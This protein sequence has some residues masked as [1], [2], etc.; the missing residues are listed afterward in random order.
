MEEPLVS[1]GD[2]A[3]SGENLE[4]E[5]VFTDLLLAAQPGEEKQAGD[6]IIAAEEPKDSDV[7]E[8]AR[9][10]LALSHDLRAA[11]LL[12]NSELRMNGFAGFAQVTSYIRGCLQEYWE[13]CHPQLD[14]E[15]DDDPTMRVNAALGLAG[16][17]T[18]IRA[19]RVAPLTQSNSFGRIGLRDIAVADGEVPASPDAEQVLDQAGIAAAFKDTDS[20]VLKEIYSA[21]S[22]ALEDV[23]AINTVFDEKIPGLG[24]D[25]DPLIKVLNRAVSRLAEET[26]EENIADEEA[27]GEE[28]AAPQK[29]GAGTGAITSPRDVEMALDRI[30]VYYA[31]FEPSSPLPILLKR[32]KRLVGADFMTIVKDIAPSGVDNV[33][34]VGGIE[35]EG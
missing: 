4:Y 9:E 29:A 18:V 17:D 16:S 24:P 21:A 2:D 12:A 13:T 6:E 31:S 5:K 26:G 33:L 32:A 30:I 23:K 8:K 10:V 3:P 19:L 11:V 35:E 28:G 14:A 1:F 7:A 22:M 15:D 34:T 20:D 25:L 27:A